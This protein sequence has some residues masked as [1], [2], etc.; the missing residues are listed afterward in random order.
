MNEIK[1]D[2]SKLG[3]VLSTLHGA[4]SGLEP[5]MPGDISGKNQLDVVKT[6][7]EINQLFEQ[8]IRDYQSLLVSNETMTKKSIEAMKATDEKLS[9]S[10]GPVHMR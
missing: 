8:V 10:F 9:A 1:L 5:S 6:L 7:E 2:Y 3:T 4:T